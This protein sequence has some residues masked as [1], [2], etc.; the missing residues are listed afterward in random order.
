MNVFIRY[1]LIC[2][3]VFSSFAHAQRQE[4]LTWQECVE[5]TIRNHPDLSAAAEAIKIEKA[6]R[7]IT[8]SNILPQIS[9]EANKSWGESNGRSSMSGTP[10][11]PST[12]NSYGVSGQQLVFDGFKSG[13]ELKSASRTVRASEYGYN[14]VSANIRLNLRTAFINLLKAQNS[15][16]ITQSILTRRRQNMELVGLRYEGGR[17]HSG[18]LFTASANLAEAEY[19]V[20]AA[21]RDLMLAQDQLAKELGRPYYSPITVKGSF[22]TPGPQKKQPDFEAL[23]KESPQFKELLNKKEASHMTVNAAKA[24][25]FPDLYLNTSVGKSSRQWPP[26]DNEWTVGMNLSLPVFEG[27]LQQAQLKKARA[28]FRSAGAQQNSLLNS[29][30][31]TL[32]ETWTGWENSVDASH[33]QQQFL[34]AAIERAKI[35]DAQYSTGLITFNDWIIIENNLVNA[36]KALLEAEAN[37]LLAEARWLQSQGRPLDAND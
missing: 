31:Y 35:S 36:R 21:K 1:I 10:G 28:Q 13:Y 24:D 18:A 17:E 6:N 2:L 23:A 33:V 34:T 26:K 29:L 37:V 4:V 22:K 32:K 14:T 8:L 25:F 9:A 11:A 27:G 30:V 16:S 19:W 15:L 5:E 20:V 7:D 12:Q 3:F